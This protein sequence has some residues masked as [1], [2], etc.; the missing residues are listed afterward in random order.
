MLTRRGTSLTTSFKPDPPSEGLAFNRP[1]STSLPVAPA[2]TIFPAASI[3][4]VP[5]GL[6]TEVHGPL[7]TWPNR[8]LPGPHSSRTGTVGAVT[9]TTSTGPATDSGPNQGVRCHTS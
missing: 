1:T 3:F 9:C 8:A 2:N 4:A 6:R 5:S 7:G